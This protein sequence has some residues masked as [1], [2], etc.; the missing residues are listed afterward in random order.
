MGLLP[1]KYCLGHSVKASLAKKSPSH[2][3]ALLNYEPP[4][5]WA[6]THQM[7]AVSAANHRTG[8]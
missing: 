1:L 4:I 5:D 3:I 6:A 8:G 7:L 2:K